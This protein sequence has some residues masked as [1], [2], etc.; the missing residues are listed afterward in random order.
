MMVFLLPATGLLLPLR[1]QSLGLSAL[2][3]GACAA[4]LLP[5][6]LMGV[7]GVADA[8]IARLGR[9]RAIYAAVGA[10]AL[11]DWA[12]SQPLLFALIGLSMSVTRQVGQTHRLL[13]M[14]EDFRARMTAGHIAIA[15]LAAAVAPA[16]ASMLLLRLPVAQIYLLLAAGFV[17]SGALLLAVPQL[18]RF[19][20]LDPA[21]LKNL[22]GRQ[23]PDAFARRR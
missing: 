7:A 23:H 16:L 4:A 19:L 12:P 20:L 13:A 6:V 5:G 10:I 14:P 9:L 18:P 2:C 8:L 15:Q 1:L 17:L 3:F 21:E 11:C 22:Y